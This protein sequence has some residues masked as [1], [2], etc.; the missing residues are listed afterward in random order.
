[1]KKITER[2]QG[3]AKRSFLETCADGFDNV[4]AEELCCGIHQEINSPLGNPR[5][6]R[7]VRKSN[8]QETYYSPEEKQSEIR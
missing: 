2:G 6:R 3:P 8:D 5:W 7:T 4:K 1:M